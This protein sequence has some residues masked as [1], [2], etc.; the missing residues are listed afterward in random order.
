VLLLPISSDLSAGGEY[1][2]LPDFGLPLY[3]RCSGGCAGD[4]HRSRMQILMDH[5][6]LDG[7]QLGY[8]FEFPPIY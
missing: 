1:V 8:I 5:P 7:L 4:S 3:L 2:D 6:W